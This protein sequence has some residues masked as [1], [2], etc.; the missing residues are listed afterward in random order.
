M[1]EEK[2]TKTILKCTE[3][4]EEVDPQGKFA[5]FKE[6]H[7]GIGEWD[8]LKEDLY[9]EA[10]IEVEEE[11]PPWGGTRS[12]G[13]RSPR[14]DYRSLERKTTVCVWNLGRQRE[15]HSRNHRAGPEPLDNLNGLY[16]HI[17]QIVQGC[18]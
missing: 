12:A 18:E 11:P 4:G 14:R 16:F 7:R 5:H 13:G 9:E 2:Q 3:C 1:A 10:E 6:N 8:D 17:K 15:G